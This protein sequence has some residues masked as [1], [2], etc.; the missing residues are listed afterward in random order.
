MLGWI[1]FL[2]GSIITFILLP[3]YLLI[4]AM[5]VA[6]LR[7]RQASSRNTSQSHAKFIII[8]PAHNEQ[9]VIA[10]TVKSALSTAYPTSQRHLIVIADNCTDHTAQIAR[11]AGAEVWE[12]Q[13]KQL[14]GK[15]YALAYSVNRILNDATLSQY[16]AVIIID[17]DTRC[18][19][20]LLQA[21]ARGLDA[22]KDWMQGYYNGSNPDVSWRTQLMTFALALMNGSWLAGED[23]L[24]LGA[25]LRGNGMCFSLAGLHRHPWHASGLAEDIEFSWKLR[26]AGEKIAFQ[27]DAKVFGELVSQGNKGAVSQRQRWEHGRRV[28]R[29]QFSSALRQN[30]SFDTLKKWLCL[31]NLY[32]LPLAKLA[33]LLMLATV[34]VFA[35]RPHMA[36][37]LRLQGFMF[38]LLAFYAVTPFIKWQVPWRYL[39]SL[40]FLPQYVLWKL[41]LSVQA[42]PKDWVRTQR[43][44]EKQ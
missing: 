27:A 39:L 3:F 29:S 33:G 35:S 5:A 24:G 31:G 16:T 34:L 37:L 28:V 7:Y 22:G 32:M 30:Q 21:F 41:K 9:T 6:A 13:D 10:D 11:D 23:V 17:A 43:E 38:A 42:Q 20:A 36:I 1:G 19:E 40:R 12:R 14:R 18:D 44:N 4:G 26:L 8:I 25:G 15:G 2:I